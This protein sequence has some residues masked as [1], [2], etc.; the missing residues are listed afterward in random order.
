LWFIIIKFEVRGNHKKSRTETVKVVKEPIYGCR[1][2]TCTC[3]VNDVDGI[4]CRHVV[5]I[6]KSG[7]GEGLNLVNGMP[8]H[9]TTES[10]RDQFP[11]E[12]NS[13]ACMTIGLL[14]DVYEPSDHMFFIPD[15]VGVRKKGRPKTSQRFKSALEIAIRKS[16]GEKMGLQKLLTEEEL[17]L[18]GNDDKKSNDDGTADMN[19][20]GDDE[21]KIEGETAK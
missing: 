11:Q 18:I 7:R 20:G 12:L 4:M 8:Y 3:G 6:A 16:K 13:R 1:G 21:E 17:A 10:W 2:S 19:S 9:W 15:F 5:A 14:K